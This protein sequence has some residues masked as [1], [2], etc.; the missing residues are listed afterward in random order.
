MVPPVERAADRRR[1]GSGDRP[2]RHH[3]D[4]HL[5]ADGPQQ[6]RRSELRAR[7]DRER[8]LGQLHHPIRPGR[9]C[10]RHAVP[11][12]LRARDERGM[13]AW[14]PAQTQTPPT[15]SWRPTGTWSTSSARPGRRTSAGS[16][17][18]TPTG[19]PSGSMRAT[20]PAT[21]TSIGSAWTDTTWAAPP[22]TAGSPRPRSSAPATPRCGRSQ[23][24][25][26]IE[27]TASTELGGSKADWI[28]QLASTVPAQF[29]AVRAV[30]WFQRNKETDW[31]VNS[32][33]GALAAFKALAAEPGVGRRRSRC[34]R[35]GSAPGTRRASAR[36]SPRCP[37]RRCA[38][39]RPQ[40]RI[41]ADRVCPGQDGR[42]R[43]AD[44]QTGPPAARRSRPRNPC[45]SDSP[46]AP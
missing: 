10:D 8:C 18:P 42:S 21:G 7:A 6:H 29:P 44:R 27:E 26:I 38:H 15:R 13:G 32:S 5:G 35:P 17:P 11:G 43:L 45:R 23:K 16:G 34:T 24:P 41:P 37:G 20:T 12:Q 25:I 33:A 22:L 4:H 9:R 36:P 39:R 2:A 30:V 14:G 3:P 31:R 1:R 28:D 40:V 19:T 46:A